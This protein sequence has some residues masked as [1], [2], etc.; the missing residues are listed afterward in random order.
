MIDH[1]LLNFFL[2]NYS[3]L[4]INLN[5]IYY[6]LI[7]SIIDEHLIYSFLLSIIKLKKL[8]SPF[9]MFKMSCFQY[10]TNNMEKDNY[11]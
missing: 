1:L 9:L 6:Y 4:F 7:F 11:F 3:N 5:L 8:I 2:T 10:K